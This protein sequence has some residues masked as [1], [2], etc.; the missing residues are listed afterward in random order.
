M[1]HAQPRAISMAPPTRPSFFSR[2]SRAS[3]I[4][5]DA[6]SAREPRNGRVI[7]SI[8][9][10]RLSQMLQREPSSERIGASDEERTTKKKG[11]SR[12][13]K[14][15]KPKT[16]SSSRS[17]IQL[18]DR[19]SGPQPLQSL[20]NNDLA[21]PPSITY[22]V[23]RGDRKQS[24][25]RSGSEV[26][27]YNE[28][29]PYLL[30]ARS[31]NNTSFG[32]RSVS[33][34][35]NDT[36]SIGSSASPTSSRYRRE[37]YASGKE[38]E[39]RGSGMEML[40][41][42]EELP[43]GA[44]P[45]SGTGTWPPISSSHQHPPH[46]QANTSTWPPAGS[47]PAVHPVLGIR[48]HNKTASSLSNSSLPMP[49]IE[50]P[51]PGINGALSF[52]PI[53]ASQPAEKGAVTQQATKLSANRFKNL[54]PLPPPDER[55]TSTSDLPYSAS[56]DSFVAAFPEYTQ[57]RGYYPNTQQPRGYHQPR[58]SYEPVQ[59]ERGKV[60]MGQRMAQS[61]YAPHAHGV[62]EGRGSLDDRKSVKSRKGLKGL[63][64]KSGRV[65]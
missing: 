42:S 53:N 27:A 18:D 1:V 14:K 48:P 25:E 31:S 57:Q 36:S 55:N 51:P 20:E 52:F 45:P 5:G 3:S 38:F 63:F 35:I 37:S 41:I 60:E 6:A 40:G 39:R 23:D 64:G 17:T 29:Q 65:G 43:R 21:P 59:Y 11:F 33:A 10:S 46:P 56:P 15:N 9:S 24:R 19:P 32:V 49:T 62:V 61:M 7:K 16:S 44:Q 13:F 8:S 12:F 34:P 50:T 2:S 26:S 54:P 58:A 47:N 30:N 4:N 28:N 22:L